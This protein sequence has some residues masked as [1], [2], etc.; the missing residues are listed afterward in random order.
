MINKYKD[1]LNWPN[2]LTLL[3]IILL[4][5]FVVMLLNL[6]NP[7]WFWAR[8]AA[9]GIFIVM[10]LSD[11]LDG[12]LARKLNQQTSLGRFLDPLA[13]KLLI[14]SGMILLGFEKT[15]VPDF[16]LPNW[17]IVSAIGKDLFV[18][19]GFIVVFFETGKFLI[20]PSFVGKLCTAIQMTLI[21]SV[22]SAP[23]MVN[24]NLFVDD[25]FPVF[26]KI[27]WYASVIVALLTCG[28]YFKI[29]LDFVIN[30]QKAK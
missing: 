28:D 14:T 16:K 13:D 12:L 21:I 5:P 27:L 19:L 6:R 29:G 25:F 9:M 17:V 10:G 23:D 26:I 18:V 24:L 15:S 20:K 3:R 22:L 1:I 30:E 7:E 2:R 4:G 11:A 8:H